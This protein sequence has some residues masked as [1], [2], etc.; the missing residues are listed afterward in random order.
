MTKMP[1]IEE[2]PRLLQLASGPR[3]GGLERRAG[4]MWQMPPAD[5]AIPPHR[6]S[7]SL[8]PTDPSP[9]P[10]VRPEGIGQS[11]VDNPPPIPIGL[12]VRERPDAVVIDVWNAPLRRPH[13]HDRPIDITASIRP[14]LRTISPRSY[15][16]TDTLRR[17]PSWSKHHKYGK[18]DC[19]QS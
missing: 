12:L 13:R 7:P 8:P 4:Y 1:R 6:A 18:D 9:Y 5:P 15:S 3:S 2:R 11:P 19:Y 10:D 17:G 16:P 14:W